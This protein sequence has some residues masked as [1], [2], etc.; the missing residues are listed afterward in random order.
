MNSV[1]NI[2]K[3][4]NSFSITIPG[5]W[6]PRGGAETI[7]RL[8]Q[9]LKLRSQDD[10]GLHV[11]EVK[12]RGTQIKTGDKEYKL[13]DLGSQKSEII[14]ELKNVKYNNLEDMVFRMELT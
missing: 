10:I 3:E 7:T 5:H 13:S 12:K 2:T 1:F 4:N 9:L 11:Q 6:S 8:H 14:E